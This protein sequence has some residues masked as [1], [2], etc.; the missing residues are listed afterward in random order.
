MASGSLVL[1][2]FRISIALRITGS[3]RAKTCVAFINPL[4]TRVWFFLYRQHDDFNFGGLETIREADD[5]GVVFH[6]QYLSDCFHCFVFNGRRRPTWFLVSNIFAR[7]IQ[8]LGP[9]PALVATAPL[10]AVIR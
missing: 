7:Y 9:G 1:W 8:R 3:F 5:Q 2:F 10:A 4:R 6:I